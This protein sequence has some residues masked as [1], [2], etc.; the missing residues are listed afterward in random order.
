MLNKSS[1]I[2]VGDMHVKKEDIPEAK[3]FIDWLTTLALSSS[4]KPLIIFMGDQYNDFALAR[5]ESLEFWKWAY[6]RL[7]EKLGPNSSLSIVG[8]HDMNQEETATAMSAHS[9]LTVL[10]RREPV[11]INKTTAAIGF[12][13]REDLFQKIISEAYAQGARTILCHA[14]FQGAQYENGFYAPHGFD[15]SKYPSDLNFVS[16]HIHKKQQFGNVTYVGTPRPLTRSDIGETKGVHLANLLK[17]SLEF[18]PTPQEVCESFRSILIKETDYSDSV[19]E[20]IPDSSRIYVDIHG[21]KEFVQKIS[22]QLPESVKTRATYTEDNKDF[23]VRESEGIPS[24]FTKFSANYFKSTALD[25]NTQNEV[26]D[27]IYAECP[28]LKMGVR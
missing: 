1:A 14:E 28:S 9:N 15:L 20:S 18:I 22:K 6:E 11:F 4:S 12:V 13:R 19:L 5:V 2:L 27:R 7:N 25:Q 17:N 24:V 8:N 23:E 16:G 10:A 21:S 26:F 3:R